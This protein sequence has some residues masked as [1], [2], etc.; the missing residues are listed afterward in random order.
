MRKNKK[1]LKNLKNIFK[2][3][4]VLVNTDANKNFYT[5][6]YH[7]STDYKSSKSSKSINVENLY[8][9]LT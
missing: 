9:K 1:N 6:S 7:I 4:E 2:E 5:N 3:K 8:I